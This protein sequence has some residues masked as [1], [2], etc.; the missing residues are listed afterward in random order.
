MLNISVK[1]SERR[2]SG[3]H[4]RAAGI[5]MALK[6]ATERTVNWLT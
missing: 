4:L 3:G 5:S 1:W 2:V 6:I